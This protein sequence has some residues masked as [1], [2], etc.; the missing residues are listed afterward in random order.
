MP[1]FVRCTECGVEV[2][3]G[4]TCHATHRDGCDGPEE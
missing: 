3:A 1:R 2:L 4:D